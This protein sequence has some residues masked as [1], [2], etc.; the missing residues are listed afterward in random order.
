M[1]AIIQ[2]TIGQLWLMAAMC[3]VTG[4]VVA[5]T[6]CLSLRR[7][8][9]PMAL[10][11]MIGG[12]ASGQEV[13]LP[14]GVVVSPESVSLGRAL[15]FDKRLSIDSTK[16][17]S[18]CHDPQHGWVDDGPVSL[19]VRNQPGIRRSQTIENAAF[20]RANFHDGRAVT[21]VGQA[22]QP[23][24]AQAELGNQSVQQVAN[25]IARVRGY[26]TMFVDAYGRRVNG[27]DMLSAIAAFE[28]TIV[29]SDAP[30]DRYARGETWVF[31]HQQER[32]RFVFFYEGCDRC[33]SGKNFT[34][35][36]F[37]NLLGRTRDRTGQLDIG[38]GKISQRQADNFKFVTPTL[39]DVG[40]R[41]PYGHAG[42]FPTMRSFVDYLNDPVVGAEV[43]KM[44]LT[45][46]DCAALTVF[47]E[48]A[49]ESEHPPIVT[50]PSLPR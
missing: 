33:H 37:H 48:T 27:T 22:S 40:K 6:M 46:D 23:M 4:G 12:V 13:Q 9:P 21:V 39:R 1:N 30:I 34:D 35:G 50:E 31:N 43:G 42:Q 8:I 28:S 16:S 3:S 26:Q 49:F 19:G 2:I 38:R 41:A 18:S 32:G 44:N 25:R 29:S 7:W 47:L 11:L 20:K 36:Q 24:V 14:S 10:L 17:C 45:D 5:A 15:F